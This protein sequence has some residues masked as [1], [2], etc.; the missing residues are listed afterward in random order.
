MLARAAESPEPYNSSASAPGKHGGQQ[1]TEDEQSV[2]Q[3]LN[4]QLR[5]SPY[6]LPEDEVGQTKARLMVDKCARIEAQQRSVERQFA[7]Q[8]R[9]VRRRIAAITGAREVY[10]SNAI[11]N[12]GLSLAATTEAIEEA[13]TDLDLLATHM[14]N[15][16]I[17]SD[18]H[19]LEVLGL[20]R[21]NLFARK[22]VDDFRGSSIPLR[23]VD[24]RNLHHDAMAGEQWGGSYKSKDNEISGSTLKTSGVLDVEHDMRELIDWINTV[25]APPALA[26]TVVH[27]WLTSIHPFEDGNGRMARLMAN[28][29]LLRSR[30]PSL[31]V[32]SADR[33]QYLDALSFSDQGGDILPL[34]ELFLKWI[35]R[36]LSELADPDLAI[37]LYEQDLKRSPD[38]RYQVWVGLLD[39]FLSDLRVDLA[40]RDFSLEQINNPPA[41]NF[42]LLEG[43]EVNGNMWLGKIIGPREREFLLW[44]GY[45]SN[46]MVDRAPIDRNAP[47]LFVSFR[48]RRPN[49]IHQ[50]RSPFEENLLVIDEISLVPTARAESAMVRYGLTILERTPAEAAHDLASA[51]DRAKFPP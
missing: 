10:E 17:Q 13:P 7:K 33:V 18:R 12:A 1:M 16:S 34:F 35:D 48:D 15:R 21:A 39:T 32:R 37:R 28:I 11:E 36:E 47:S 9:E 6:L 8:S 29:V 5:G 2:V 31:I 45:M 26:A 44:L 46:D 30:W 51:I 3:S 14:A 38:R 40:S 24:V 4:N 19:M 23:E 42:A 27:S 49:A 41:S 22:L 20:H 43:R 25:D 50:Y